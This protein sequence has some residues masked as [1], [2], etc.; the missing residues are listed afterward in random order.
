MTAVAA[1]FVGLRFYSKLSR[2]KKLWLDDAFLVLA[3][4]TLVGTGILCIVSVRN[5][6]GLH[7]GEI[8]LD[9]VAE[10]VL[11]GCIIGTLTIAGAIWS[12]TSWA[13]TM[14]RL[15]DGWYRVFVWFAIISA[16]VYMSI[17]ALWIWV[18][19]TPI[20][21]AWNPFLPGHC[22]SPEFFIIWGIIG[23]SPCPP[24]AHLRDGSTSR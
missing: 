5:G 3:E 24:P 23:G 12:K 17:G 16:N 2:G 19:C 9:K 15:T 10:N 22:W 11:L 21:K 4:L 14:L 13:L 18:T 6:F 8:S 20:Q 7:L 1:V